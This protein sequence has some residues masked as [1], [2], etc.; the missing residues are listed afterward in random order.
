MGNNTQKKVMIAVVIVAVLVVGYFILFKEEEKVEYYLTTAS[1]DV[2][3]TLFKD[4]NSFKKF[5]DKVSDLND[6]LE[7]KA[8][9]KKS[10]LSETY[11]EDFFNEKRLALVSVYEDT[12]K[13]YIYSI[14]KVEYNSDKTEVTITYTYTY[15]TYA[16]V[17]SKTWYDYMFVELENTVETVNFVKDNSSIDS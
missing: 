3:N 16:D 14:D 7:N 9:Y 11:T 1:T 12:T 4:Y 2:E 13:D 10:S 6:T 5:Y 15:T 17:L 8:T